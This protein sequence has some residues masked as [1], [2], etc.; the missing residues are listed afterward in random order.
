MSEELVQSVI[1]TIDSTK[2]HRIKLAELNSSLQEAKTQVHGETQLPKMKIRFSIHTR[3]LLM[4]TS[5]GASFHFSP[6][7]MSVLMSH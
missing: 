7:L 5:L 6:V 4:L 3:S 1:E 2:Q